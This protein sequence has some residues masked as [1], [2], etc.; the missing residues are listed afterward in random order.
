MKNL[1][2]LSP[3]AGSHFQNRTEED[4]KHFSRGKREGMISKEEEEI[5][6]NEPLAAY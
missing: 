1:Y 2:S 5:H 3:N 6:S 4:W